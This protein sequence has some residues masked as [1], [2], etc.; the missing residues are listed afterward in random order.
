MLLSFP[1]FGGRRCIKKGLSFC[2][3]RQSQNM[4]KRMP[5]NKDKGN[6]PTPS[7]RTKRCKKAACD[8]KN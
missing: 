5:K 6:S 3:C 1:Q 7:G 8:G 4:D 2:D